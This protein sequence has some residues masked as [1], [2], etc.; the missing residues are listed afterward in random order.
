MVCA[1]EHFNDTLI[2]VLSVADIV[3][4]AVINF[5]YAA[6]PFRPPRAGLLDTF[7]HRLIL[8]SLS[9]LSDRS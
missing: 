3:N 2:F 1:I 6:H 7:K 5:S 4:I 9:K 8:P